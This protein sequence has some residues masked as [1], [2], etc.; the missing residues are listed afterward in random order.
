MPPVD[1]NNPKRADSSESTFSVMEFMREFPN[2]EACLEYLWR[3]RYAADGE[4]AHCPRCGQV[5]K[6]HRYHSPGKATSRVRQVWSCTSCSMQLS[7]TAG[8]IFHKSSTSL[9]LWFYAIW[10]ITSTRCGVSAKQLEREL[11]VTYKTA[12]RMFNLIRNQLMEQDNDPLS[13][14]VEV[15]ET[16]LKGRM[17]NAERRKRAEDGV[18]PKNPHREG[19]AVVYGAVERSG[20][21][22]ATTIPNSRARTL[23][24]QTVE[25]VLPGSVIYTDQWKPYVRLGRIGYD[26]RRINHRARI[27]VD[28]DVHTQTIDGFFGMVKNAIS[29][30]HHGVS[31]KWLQGY[32]NEYAWRYNHR[33]DREAMFRLLLARSATTS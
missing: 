1:R 3:S 16:F 13:G 2:D 6:F 29:G 32:L 18:H 30:V 15:D 4:S 24:G 28:G 23:L 12:W 31:H 21:V 19:T 25:Y 20:R 8:T 26:H 33:D 9:H 11:G 10:I 14:E 7:P 17:R 22:R 27:Y 5:R